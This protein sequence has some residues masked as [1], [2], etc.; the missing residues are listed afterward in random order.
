[1]AEHK[2]PRGT[3]MSSVIIGFQLKDRLGQVIFVDNS[4]ARLSGAPMEVEA[5]QVIRASFLFKMPAFSSGEYG[6]G[7]AIATGTQEEH[8]I[9]HFVHEAL[10]VRVVTPDMLGG[11]FR[12]PL[13]DVKL[14]VEQA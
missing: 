4:F 13:D 10:V 9:H 8:M 14:S 11:I 3:A 12:L 2:R 5:G 6:L 7:A 1:M